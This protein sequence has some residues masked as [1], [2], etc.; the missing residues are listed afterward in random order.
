MS[1]LVAQGAKSAHGPPRHA[2]F[3]ARVLAAPPF[4]PTPVKPIRRSAGK[5]LLAGSAH[6]RSALRRIAPTP[7]RRIAYT[8][9]RRSACTPVRRDARF[10]ERRFAGGQVLAGL[11]GAPGRWDADPPARRFAY[12]SASH[13]PGYGP[14]SR[15]AALWTRLRLRLAQDT[16]GGPDFAR[17]FRNVNQGHPGL[18][19]PWA[20]RRRRGDMGLPAGRHALSVDPVALDFGRSP[21]G[22]STTLNCQPHSPLSNRNTSA[23]SGAFQNGKL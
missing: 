16:S 5:T 12:P 20:G 8:P 4:R 23:L 6:R 14:R 9:V 15:T 21:V 22:A 17:D 7:V 11:A 2:R 19:G 10:A 18:R 1:Y 13:A 3:S